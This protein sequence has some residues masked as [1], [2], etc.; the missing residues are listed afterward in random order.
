MIR[1]AAGEPLPFAQGDLRLEGAAIEARVYA[2]DPYRNFLPSIGRLVR[3]RPPVGDGIRIDEGVYEGAEISLYYDPMIAKL[4]AYGATRE[5]AIERLAL[6]LDAFHIAGVSHNIP[7]LA[8]VVGKA[9]FRAGALSTA[10]IADEFPAGFTGAALTEADEAQ[11]IAIAAAAQFIAAEHDARIGGQATGRGRAAP[12]GW[13]VCRGEERHS[14]RTSRADDTIVVTAET[15]A[16]RIAT[17]W[18]P[19]QPVLDATI[20]GVTLFYQVAR[21]G[22]GLT[23]AHAGWRVDLKVLLPRAAELLAIMPER[24]AADLSHLLL[25]PMPGLLVS[26]AVAEGQEVKAG[27]EIAVIEAMKMENVLRA[28]RDGKVAKLHAKAGDSLTADQIIL[29]FA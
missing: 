21:V 22:I 5:A 4:V 29:E 11:A 18:L 3:Y 20:D 9:R 24:M 13:T 7:F 28:E 12:D 19:W 23:L 10:F 14:V 6:A 15:G 17:N 2:E 25:S 26:V 1:I 27:E 8:A 16:H